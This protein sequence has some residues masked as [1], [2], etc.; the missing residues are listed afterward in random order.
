MRPLPIVSFSY[1]SSTS[2][3]KLVARHV[4]VIEF[5]G[6]VLRGYE[7]T[8]NTANEDPGKY[9]MF[10]AHRIA[11]TI[12]LVRQEVVKMAPEVISAELV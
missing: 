7:I 4:R 3:K 11:G 9:K 8:E 6:H 10:H 5:D 12:H 1:P 2:S